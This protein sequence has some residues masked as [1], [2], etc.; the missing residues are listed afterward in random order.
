MTV[1]WQCLVFACAL[2]RPGGA[3]VYCDPTVPTDSEGRGEV[4][5]EEGRGCVRVISDTHLDVKNDDKDVG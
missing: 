5:C 2:A 1:S 3:C 4:E